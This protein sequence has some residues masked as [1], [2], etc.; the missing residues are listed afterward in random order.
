MPL[1]I[2]E[3]DWDRQTGD[4]YHFDN[5]TSTRGRITGIAETS[6]DLKNLSIELAKKILGSGSTGYMTVGYAYDYTGS[7]GIPY[8]GGTSA[9]AGIDYRAGAGTRVSAAVPGKVV[10][11]V[12]YGAI[13]QFVTV[14]S[15]DGQRRWVYGHVDSSKRVGETLNAGDFIGSV[16][17]QSGN[18]H[19]HLEVHTR[20]A[21]GFAAPAGGIPVGSN[22]NFVLANTISPLQA[23]WDYKNRGGGSPN[24]YTGTEGNDRIVAG[25]GNDTLTGLGG[26]DT[27]Y[28]EA[29]NDLL[30]G[31]SGNDYLDGYASFVSR[32]YD[33]LVGGTGIDTFVLGNA[34]QGV[35]YKGLGYA[36]IADYNFRDD[37]IQLRGNASQ[38]QLSIQG[39]D[40]SILQNGDLIG[41]VKNVTDLSLTPRPGRADFKFV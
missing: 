11:V 28:G 36:V 23:F 39:N 5:N 40:T 41:V 6:T 14:E 9:H 34:G 10:N 20:G 33:T 19:F 32:D 16:K 12:N 30:N 31:G 35:F 21:N 26:N 8:N 4:A 25:S 15:F 24:P 2:T 29:G 3:A 18:T 38:Y 27:L 22:V 37:Y 7:N 1:P 17:N 13:G